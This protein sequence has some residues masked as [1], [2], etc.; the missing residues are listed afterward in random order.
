[1]DDTDANFLPLLLLVNSNVLNVSNLPKP[2][3][4]LALNE[5][6]TDANDGVRGPVEDDEGEV[7]FRCR[8]H[9]G[10]LSAPG[11]FTGIG[12]LSEDGENC[13]MPTGIIS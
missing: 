6:G 11:G 3:Q 1:M 2:S 9:C 5:Q 8:L 12:H 4:K 10:E 7:G 13:E